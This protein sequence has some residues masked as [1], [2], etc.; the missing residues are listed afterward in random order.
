MTPSEC[1]ERLR[2]TK[3][4]VFN[5]ALISP[6]R[7]HSQHRRSELVRSAQDGEGHSDHTMQPPPHRSFRARYL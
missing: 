4:V 7:H 1:R 2:K 6:F 3:S 5:V